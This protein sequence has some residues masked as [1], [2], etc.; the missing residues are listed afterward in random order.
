MKPKKKIP[1][2]GQREE[3]YGSLDYE[4]DEEYETDVSFGL[5]YNSIPCP[6][7]LDLLLKMAWY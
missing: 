7:F 5:F 3:E 2:V 1:G 6:Y 4:S